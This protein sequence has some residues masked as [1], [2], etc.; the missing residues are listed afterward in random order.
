MGI[1]DEWMLVTPTE[2]DIEE[3]IECIME[4]KSR[5]SADQP[6]TKYDQEAA[7]DWAGTL[8]DSV[9]NWRELANCTSEYIVSKLK[10][11]THA[12]ACIPTSDTV[13]NWI[14]H[15]QARSLEEI[16]LEIVDGDQDAL[17]LLQQKAKSSSPRD[18]S[19]WH[20]APGMLLDVLVSGIEEP[21]ERWGTADVMR[22]IGRA[23]TAL[24]VCAWLEL[25][26]SSGFLDS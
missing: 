10:Q 11:D 5:K 14:D 13:Q 18:L 20:S 26:T 24:G 4:G 12:K 16:M 3:L 23:K 15:A 8:L 9:R 17:E 2:D 19:N 25:F 7:K 22:W 1:V 6:R 21:C